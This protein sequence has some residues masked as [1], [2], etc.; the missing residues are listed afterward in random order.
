MKSF[1]PSGWVLAY[2]LLAVRF[3]GL[4]LKDDYHD[5]IRP[6]YVGPCKLRACFG[7]DSVFAAVLIKVTDEKG[8]SRDKI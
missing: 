6:F 2:H 1:V 4:L 5:K 7:C 3:A 8:I